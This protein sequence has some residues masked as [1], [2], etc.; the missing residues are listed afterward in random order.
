M[1]RQSTA[2]W[3]S[4]VKNSRPSPL[5]PGLR[6]CVWLPASA[7]GAVPATPA[8]PSVTHLYPLIDPWHFLCRDEFY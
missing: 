6:A 2:G 8:T 5:P 1:A 4:G 3:D 7:M